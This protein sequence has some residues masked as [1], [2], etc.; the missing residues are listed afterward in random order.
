[1]VL[2]SNL[3]LCFAAVI[4]IHSSPRQML[5]PLD[6]LLHE[7]WTFKVTNRMLK[8]FRRCYEIE[9]GRA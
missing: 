5:E 6:D 2:L 1:M 4:P 3:N 7:A 9:E 8:D